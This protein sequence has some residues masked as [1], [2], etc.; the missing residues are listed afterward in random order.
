MLNKSDLVQIK[1]SGVELTDVTLASSDEPMKI[2][3]YH[4]VGYCK[5]KKH[6]KHF[7]SSENCLE[8]KCRNKKYI[9]RHRKPCRFGETCIRIESCEFFHSE[10]RRTTTDTSGENNTLKRLEELINSKDAQVLEL[11]EKVKLLEATVNSL[12]E[13]IKESKKET[14]VNSKKDDIKDAEKEATVISIKEGIKESNT[15]KT[16]S[17]TKEEIQESR[18]KKEHKNNREEKN[19][20]VETVKIP[21]ERCGEFFNSERQLRYHKNQKH[22][23]KT[24]VVKSTSSWEEEFMGR[25]STSAWEDMMNEF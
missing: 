5:Y 4:R 2:C 17:S 22:V 6:C 23:E 9:K 20:K 7:H 10:Q 1:M 16:V 24:I 8:N 11:T 13:D 15:E 19:S 3:P 12:K 21:C 25:K 18:N 14:H